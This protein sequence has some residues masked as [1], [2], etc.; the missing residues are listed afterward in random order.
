M[1]IDCI[2]A[3]Y[4]TIFLVIDRVGISKKELSYRILKVSLS[5]SKGNLCLKS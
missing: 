4:R 1:L 5:E 2:T 3:Y